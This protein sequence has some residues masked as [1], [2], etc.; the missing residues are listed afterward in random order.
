VNRSRHGRRASR[1]ADRRTLS[2]VVGARTYSVWVGMLHSL[3]PDGRTHRL[4]VIVAG[5]LRH[6]VHLAVARFGED[7]PEG[8]V[9]A[10]LIQAAHEVDPQRAMELIGSLIERLFR[11][12]GVSGTRVTAR[13][14]EYSILDSAV[15]EFT[16]W[17]AMPWE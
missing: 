13:G 9:A 5:M 14:D 16:A 4:S 6:A 1:K 3:V 7:A 10:S 2:S 15:Q 11:D 8:S 17:H 12:A